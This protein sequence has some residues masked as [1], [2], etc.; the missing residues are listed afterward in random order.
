MFAPRFVFVAWNP[1]DA[2]NDLAFSPDGQ[3]LA[4]VSA[5]GFVKLWPWRLLLGLGETTSSGN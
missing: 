3:T 5:A 4:T 1:D 2:V